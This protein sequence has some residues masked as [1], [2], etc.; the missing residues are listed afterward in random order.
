MGS[1]TPLVTD[2]SGGY[3]LGASPSLV[4]PPLVRIASV[5]APPLQHV[6]ASVAGALVA[7]PDGEHSTVA[8]FL[9]LLEQ[10]KK[11]CELEGKYMEAEIAKKRLEEVRAFFYR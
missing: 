10:H 2:F 4:K 9:E 7:M 8:D 3:T 6:M 1:A 5:G 11:N